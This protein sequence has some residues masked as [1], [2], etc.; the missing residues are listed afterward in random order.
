M[1]ETLLCLIERQIEKFEITADEIGDVFDGKVLQAATIAFFAEYADFFLQTGQVEKV[2]AISETMTSSA[3]IRQAVAER[4]PEKIA[5]IT[6][7]LIS[8]R[9]S[10]NTPEASELTPEA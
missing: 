6:S 3:R 4:I 8:E 9:L 10:G 5:A 1:M 7:D 2:A